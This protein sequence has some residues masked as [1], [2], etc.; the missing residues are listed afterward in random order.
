MYSSRDKQVFVVRRVM[1]EV[2]K[3]EKNRDMFGSLRGGFYLC[4]VVGD[5]RRNR[6]LS[7]DIAS[8]K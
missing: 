8:T 6:L 5:G 4:S 1:T 7:V 2:E 3:N